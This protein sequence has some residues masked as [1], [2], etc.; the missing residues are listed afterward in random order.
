MEAGPFAIDDSN[1]TVI[2]KADLA[3]LAEEAKGE[4]KMYRP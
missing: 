4:D 1:D 3:G 2:R